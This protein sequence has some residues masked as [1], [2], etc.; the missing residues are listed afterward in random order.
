VP[1]AGKDVVWLVDVPIGTRCRRYDQVGLTSELEDLLGV[2][3]DV[4]SDGAAGV[5]RIKHTVA[6]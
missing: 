2:R 3:V 4:I 5:D 6:V 1:Q